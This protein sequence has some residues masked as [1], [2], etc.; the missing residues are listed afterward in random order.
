MRLLRLEQL[1]V[2]LRLVVVAGDDPGFEEPRRRQL[3]GV[4]GDDDAFAADEH[5][6]GLLEAALRR[7]V[8]DDDVEERDPREQLGHGGRPGHP[9]G[10]QVEERVAAV[11]AGAGLDDLPE[12]HGALAAEHEPA[13]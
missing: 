8:K 11:D 3:L 13:T 9:D 12:P 1:L 10:A 4:A 5:R 7:L 6:Q 2:G